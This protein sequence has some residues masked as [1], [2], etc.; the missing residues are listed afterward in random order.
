M[1]LAKQKSDWDRIAELWVVL[2]NSN[3]D[4]KQTPKPYTHDMVHPF[5]TAEDYR[6]RQPQ[7]AD[8]TELKKLVTGAI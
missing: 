2:A 8:L 7:R 6:P 3:R 5:R 4:P 1:A